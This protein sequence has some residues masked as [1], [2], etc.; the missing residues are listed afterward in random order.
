MPDETERVQSQRLEAIPVYSQVPRLEITRTRRADDACGYG[1]Q[2]VVH[3]PIAQ[4]KQRRQV[5]HSPTRIP[6]RYYLVLSLFVHDPLQ[7]VSHQTMA[8]A[9][10]PRWGWSARMPP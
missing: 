7:R 2:W 6:T 8:S 5:H 10:N 1:D 9:A 4:L 3:E